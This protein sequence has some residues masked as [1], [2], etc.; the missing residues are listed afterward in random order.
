MG[1]QI[2]KIYA[3][4]QLSK[5]AAERISQRFNDQINIVLGKAI[6]IAKGY[7]VGYMQAKPKTKRF[8]N[9]AFFEKLC[10]KDRKIYKVEYTDLFGA[11]FKKSSNT[12]DLVEAVVRNLNFSILNQL[13]KPVKKISA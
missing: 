4:I 11:L 10:V 12:D 7:G 6:K 5:K 13:S 2:E 1:G 8:F 9:Q 3:D